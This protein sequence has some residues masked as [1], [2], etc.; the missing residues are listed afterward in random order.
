[1][2]GTKQSVIINVIGENLKKKSTAVNIVLLSKQLFEQTNLSTKTHKHAVYFQNISTYQA[3]SHTHDT[4]ITFS[5]V[6]QYSVEK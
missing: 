2:K 3:T 5:V 4:L 1:M 6:L